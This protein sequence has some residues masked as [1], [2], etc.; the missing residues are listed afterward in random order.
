MQPSGGTLWFVVC[1]LPPSALAMFAM[2][3]V[4]WSIAGS[5]LTWSTVGAAVAT[6]HPHFSAASV[7]VMLLVDTVLYAVVMLL[8]DRWETSDGLFATVW[9]ACARALSRI[10]SPEEL[11]TRTLPPPPTPPPP[12]ALFLIYPQNDF[13]WSR[14]NP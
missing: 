13:P 12:S 11:L 7:I 8:I 9:N 5:G 2:T 4:A 1:L 3:L 6:A 10:K 14:I